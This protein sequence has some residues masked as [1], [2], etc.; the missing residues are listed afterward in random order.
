MMLT[1][2]QYALEI[3]Y[4]FILIT[5]IYVGVICCFLLT[6]KVLTCHRHCIINMFLLHLK[7]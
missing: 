7:S 5:I 2:G 4:V 3:K 6:F 1:E